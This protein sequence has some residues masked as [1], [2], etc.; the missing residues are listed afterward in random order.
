VRASSRRLIE[1]RLGT[2]AL[3]LDVGGAARPF[4]RADWI[5]DLLPYEGR[6]Q[7]GWDGERGGERFGPETW[8][9][10][11]I[12]DRAPWPFSDDQFDFSVCSHTLEDVRDPVWV[13]QELQRVSRAGYIEV[14]ALREELTYGIQGPWVGWGHHHWLALV[15]TAGIEFVFKHHVVNR[16]G[17]HLPSGSIEGLD[18]EARTQALWWEG[19]FTVGERFLLTP[20]ALDGF[21]E[22]T[23]AEA[24]AGGAVSARA[25]WSRRVLRRASWR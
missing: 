3:V 16:A 18:E 14:P 17:S 12:C 8:V 7:L 19:A 9:R 11:D 1:E 10:R 4:P 13:C 25:P 21:L 24:L 23:V 15:T 2:D 22:G 5:L 6:G 20:A